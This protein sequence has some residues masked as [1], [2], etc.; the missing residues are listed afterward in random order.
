MLWVISFMAF[1]V[2]YTITIFMPSILVKQG[3]GIASSLTSTLI[4]T[5]AA[6]SGDPRCVAGHYWRRR[7]VL[8]Y[9]AIA[10]IVIA[11]AFVQ[12]PNLA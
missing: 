1:G 5:S 7:I 6:S 8:G 2:M 10:A 11:I 9:G 3:D 12:P 4:I